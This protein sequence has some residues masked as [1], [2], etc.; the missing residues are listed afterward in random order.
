MLRSRLCPSL[1]VKANAIVGNTREKEVWRLW[2]DTN[3]TEESLSLLEL[4]RPLQLAALDLQFPQ[5]HSAGWPQA[6]ACKVGH[7]KEREQEPHSQHISEEEPAI[8]PPL[9]CPGEAPLCP[10]LGSPV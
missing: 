1:Q 10:V 3:P 5:Q 7:P 6:Q 9:L 4:C 2:G 8:Q